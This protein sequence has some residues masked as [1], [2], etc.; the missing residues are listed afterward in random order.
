[1]LV[2]WLTVDQRL[3]MALEIEEESAIE[4]M[5]PTWTEWLPAYIYAEGV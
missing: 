2:V 3:E 5:V 1:M 4:V